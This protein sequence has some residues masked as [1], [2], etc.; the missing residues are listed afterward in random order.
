MD[1]PPLFELLPRPEPGK[2]CCRC[3]AWKPLTEFNRMSKSPDGRQAQCREC[4]RQY[5]YDNWE[6]HMA[7]IKARNRRVTNDN[8]RRLWDYLLDHSCVDC[9][10]SDPV[11]LEFDH[12]RD[13]WK[14]VTQLLRGH[15]WETILTEIEK[16]DVVCANCHRRRTN[17]R[18]E[19][20]RTHGLPALPGEFD[21]DE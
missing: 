10:E 9:G 14:N 5:H 20:W 12:L 13:K 1:Q 6:R 15:C 21:F 3:K 19:S 2:R 11:V 8:K 18:A 4:N 7:Q 16:C 17:M